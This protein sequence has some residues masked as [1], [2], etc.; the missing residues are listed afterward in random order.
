MERPQHQVQRLIDRIERRK[1][2]RI[3]Q[4]PDTL[5]IYGLKIEDN[6]PQLD[7]ALRA[8]LDKAAKNASRVLHDIVVNAI[9][10][11]NK[12]VAGE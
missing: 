8:S 5:S 12:S 11:A 4:K 7:D 2:E 9:K 10:H 1:A 3:R 6:D